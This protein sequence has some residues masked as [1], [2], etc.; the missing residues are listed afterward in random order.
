MVHRCN[1]SRHPRRKPA[2]FALARRICRFHRATGRILCAGIVPL[3]ILG[4]GIVELEEESNDM[5]KIFV[6]LIEFDVEDFDVTSASRADLT[7][8]RI[9]HGI[10]IRRHESNRGSEINPDVRF[11]ACW[12][13]YAV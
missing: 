8:R 11:R 3:T 12:C 9:H 2:R 5:F 7:V 10:G 1:W 6:R 4:D 13:M